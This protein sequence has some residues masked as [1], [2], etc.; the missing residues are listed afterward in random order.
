MKC[1][2]CGLVHETTCP[3]IK[4][5]EYHENGIVKRVEFVTD[6]DR[7]PVH[8]HDHSPRVIEREP[9]EAEKERI[10][11]NYMRRLRM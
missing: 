1:E 3:R 2:H 5:I 10:A 11:R 6:A 8:H 4:A 7:R 9:S